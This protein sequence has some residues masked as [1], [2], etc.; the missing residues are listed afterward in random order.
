MDLFAINSV[1][2]VNDPARARARARAR[3]ILSANPSSVGD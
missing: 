1:Y 2:E 3:M